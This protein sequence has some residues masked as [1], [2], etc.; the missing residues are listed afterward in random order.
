[1]LW[2]KKNVKNDKRQK[3]QKGD[4]GICSKPEEG[5]PRKQRWSFYSRNDEYVVN[6]LRE[7]K[8]NAATGTGW[9]FF[10]KY[11]IF[12]WIIGFIDALDG[13]Q[14]KGYSR[15]L[16][17]ITKLILSYSTKILLGLN[18]LNKVPALLFKEIA[19]LQL[20]G[21]TAIEIKEGV[22][23]RGKGKSQPIFGSGSIGVMIFFK[24]T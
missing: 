18:S 17:G 4:E 22:C 23:K 3:G 8:A 5:M 16:V 14:G 6:K 10:D 13:V 24:H 9:G 20:I 21:F 1:M 15:K 7:G 11:F 2:D 19:L 12:L